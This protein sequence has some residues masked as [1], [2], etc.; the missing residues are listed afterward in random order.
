MLDN[1]SFLSERHPQI[2]MGSQGVEDEPKMSTLTQRMKEA[3][4]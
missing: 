2:F 3:N 4:H 1:V